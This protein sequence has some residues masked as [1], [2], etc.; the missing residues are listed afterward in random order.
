MF[1]PTPPGLFCSGG[2]RPPRRTLSRD[3]MALCSQSHIW[4]R[5]Q[6]W[7]PSSV[8]THG[9]LSAKGSL[10]P[11]PSCSPA[12]SD[13]PYPCF[14]SPAEIF[15]QWEQSEPHHRKRKHKINNSSVSLWLAL[16]MCFAQNLNCLKA[17]LVWMLAGSL[18]LLELPDLTRN[19]LCEEYQSLSCWRQMSR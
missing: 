12:L 17:C 8:P 11:S 13:T 15:G 5:H 16:C 18:F 1:L 9:W 10:P 6:P 7:E 19:I 3:N 4:K 14:R 2:C